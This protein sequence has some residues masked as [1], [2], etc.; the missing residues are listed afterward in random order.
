[1]IVDNAHTLSPASAGKEVILI[2]SPHQL[3]HALCALRFDRESR[4]IARE[5]PATL[6]LWS[7]QLMDHS[8]NSKSR[9]FFDAALKSFPFITGVLPSLKE[10]KGPLSAYRKLSKRAEWLREYLNITPGECAA[11]YYS[12]DAS[13]EHT[14]QAFMQAL[15]AKRNIC[16]GDSPGF[17]Y[18][19]IKPPAPTFDISLRGLKHFFWF[20]RVNIA[21][22]WIA[23]ETALTVIDFDDLDRTLPHPKHTIIPTEILVQTLTTLKQFF[24]PVLQLEQEI[25]A[26]SKTEPTWVLILSNF[27]SSKLT[28]E[29]DELELYVQICSEHVLPGGTIYIKKHAGTPAVFVTQLLRRLENYNAKKLPDSLDCLP[30]E[31]LSQVLETCG[32][33]SVSSASAL[34]SLLQAPN[35]IHALTAENIDMFFRPAHKEYMTIANKQILKKLHMPQLHFPQHLKN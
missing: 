6:V 12:H 22:E 4:N 2:S 32:I 25:G 26:R 21:A 5:T 28:S 27:T 13:S 11:F 9:Q 16:Y 1:M 23:A 19:N 17:L 8:P 7:Y 34:L 3:L 24:A 33:I 10:R 15:S 31:F 30:I 18:P 29:S 35:L 14:A 20:T